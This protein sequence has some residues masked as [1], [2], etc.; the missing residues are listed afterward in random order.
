MARKKEIK[1]VKDET[2]DSLRER[3]FKLLLKENFGKTEEISTRLD[4]L[5]K[6]INKRK[7]EL[8]IK[9]KEQ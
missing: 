8:I 5:E 3:Y 6:A 9:T 2:L 4:N 1:V 7:D